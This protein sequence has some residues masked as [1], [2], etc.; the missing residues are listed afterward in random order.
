MRSL[1]C[2]IPLRGCL[3]F[4][5]IRKISLY[6]IANVLCGT[7]RY[8]IALGFSTFC[9]SRQNTQNAI[10]TVGANNNYFKTHLYYKKISKYLL[11]YV[12]YYYNS[13]I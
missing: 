7:V 12:K 13:T 8:T 9:F 4:T 1:V 3:Y 5:W 10:Y 2:R 11:E 6:C